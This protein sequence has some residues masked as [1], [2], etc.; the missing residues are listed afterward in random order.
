[1]KLLLLLFCV[2]SLILSPPPSIGVI[3]VS[4]AEER[5]HRGGRRRNSSR[6]LQKEVNGTTNTT[7]QPPSQIPS[8]LFSY[9]PSSSSSSTTN[10]SFIDEGMRAPSQDDDEEEETDPEV[11]VPLSFTVCIINN[12]DGLIDEAFELRIVQAAGS[13]TISWDGYMENI[14]GSNAIPIDEQ[15]P[16]STGTT[17]CF[18][19]V[20]NPA[21]S[22]VFDYI[23]VVVQPTDPTYYEASLL[24]YVIITAGLTNEVLS[25]NGPGISATVVQGSYSTPIAS[26]TKCGEF[27]NPF[28]LDQ[29]NPGTFISELYYS[30]NDCLTTSLPQPE[31]TFLCL[32]DGLALAPY[33]AC[34][35]DNKPPGVT[36]LAEVTPAYGQPASFVYVNIFQKSFQ[37]Y[38]AEWELIGV[39]GSLSETLSTSWN[40]QE[41]SGKTIGDAFTEGFSAATKVGFPGFASETVTVSLSA[42]EKISRTLTQSLS[43]SETVSNTCKS[44]P[45]NGQ[46]YQWKVSA[47]TDFVRDCYFT[48]VDLHLPNPPKCP[49]GFC[50]NPNCQ[51]CNSRW[52]Q[53]DSTEL[54]ALLTSNGCKSSCSMTGKPCLVDTDCCTGRCDIGMTLNQCG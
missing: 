39:G 49:L 34:Y 31:T 32:F 1:M 29:S 11:T 25:S 54:D 53:E 21:F 50:T 14:G 27:V 24:N 51:C 18:N 17:N 40:R 35:P 41:T 47:E 43:T 12:L 2:C 28:N 4:A 16:V 5:R 7:S 26:E 44:N 19:M 38:T 15:F 37:E 52:W 9:Q 30:T 45:C 10:S 42:T 23:A 36:I 33:N 3:S 48:C 22:S 13:G 46:L 6:I 8:S 20:Y